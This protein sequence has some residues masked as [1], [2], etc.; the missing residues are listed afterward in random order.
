MKITFYIEYLFALN[1]VINYIILRLTQFFLSRTRE[2]V[3]T[4][5]CICAMTSCL[6]LCIGGVYKITMC[7]DLLI[8]PVIAV[9]ILNYK[10]YK[11]YAEAGKRITL[12]IKDIWTIYI[13]TI[14]FGSIVG[15]I[16]SHTYIGYLVIQFILKHKGLI[17]ILVYSLYGGIVY[18]LVLI[19]VKNVKNRYTVKLRE[20]KITL[21]YN[22]KCINAIGLLDSGN[23]L[24]YGI[25]K[26]PVSI[27]EYG[28]IKDILNEC[29]KGLFTVMYKSVGKDGGLLYGLVFDSMI[30]MTQDKRIEVEKPYIG[31]YKG[32]L[33]G[34]GEYNMIIHK[35]YLYDI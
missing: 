1:L 29:P 4:A 10:E 23:A 5:A 12:L 13:V 25:G 9:V 17:N 31:I 11:A 18:L 6:L 34:N 33:A 20:A 26:K 16:L 3:L 7:L 19:M 2:R 32:R 27:I 28:L 24:Y 35:D 8:T 30:I 22:K 21:Q 14:L 15:G